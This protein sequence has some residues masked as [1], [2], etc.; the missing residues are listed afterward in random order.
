MHLLCSSV[1]IG[2]VGVILDTCKAHMPLA[3]LQV[4]A[5]RVGFVTSIWSDPYSGPGIDP[6]HLCRCYQSFLELAFSAQCF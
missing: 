6:S 3:I 5:L 2:V 1:K 4:E